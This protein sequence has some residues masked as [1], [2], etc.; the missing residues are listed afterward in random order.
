L[1]AAQDESVRIQDPLSESKHRT[2]YDYYRELIRL[3]TSVASLKNLSKKH[4]NVICLDDP[5][6][7]VP[8]RFFEGDDTL[9]I[10]HFG[11]MSSTTPAEANSARRR[12]RPFATAASGR[13]T[14]CF[15]VKAFHGPLPV[16]LQ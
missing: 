4:C 11:A 8:E 7:I 9:T 3:R 6:A 12:G 13:G 2:I 5:P 1:G 14:N 10:L 16:L 15:D